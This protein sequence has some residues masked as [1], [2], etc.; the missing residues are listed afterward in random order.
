MGFFLLERVAGIEPASFDWQPN[1]LPL[2]HTRSNI[3]GAAGQNRTDYARLFQRL[4][5]LYHHP[6]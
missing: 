4:L 6:L 5:G 1:V 2:N 3:F